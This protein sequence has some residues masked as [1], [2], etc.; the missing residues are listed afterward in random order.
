M[1][2]ILLAASMLFLFSSPGQCLTGWLPFKSDKIY[3]DN[4]EPA[5]YGVKR[6]SWK[7][8]FSRFLGDSDGETE[9]NTASD[10]DIG[11]SEKSLTDFENE[12]LLLEEEAK[13]AERIA[14]LKRK[15]ADEA[16]ARLEQSRQSYISQHEENIRVQAELSHR[17]HP[18]E[19]PRDLE[20]VNDRFKLKQKPDPR[21]VSLAE[22]KAIKQQIIAE[23]MKTKAL[24]DAKKEAFDAERR[25]VLEESDIPRIESAKQCFLNETE[26]LCSAWNGC[27]WNR[28][29]KVCDVDCN[30]VSQDRRCVPGAGYSYRRKLNDREINRRQIKCHSI[31]GIRKKPNFKGKN[32]AALL[33]DHYDMERICSFNSTTGCCV[34]RADRFSEGMDK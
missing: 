33:N 25:M 6:Y 30:S 13:E 3:V 12:A 16:F 7:K 19:Y 23:K 24:S 5:G 27:K 20:Y 18:V 8:P 32:Q 28:T 29:A 17:E 22:A 14:Q 4:G 11:S 15:V 9:S 26:E 1:I 34:D 21:S 31:I 10:T 2:N